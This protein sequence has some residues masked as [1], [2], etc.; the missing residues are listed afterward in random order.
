MRAGVRACVCARVWLGVRLFG[1]LTGEPGPSRGCAD[2]AGCRGQPVLQPRPLNK[3]SPPDLCSPPQAG[4]QPSPRVC[5]GPGTAGGAGA[6]AGRWVGG[7]GVAPSLDWERKIPAGRHLSPATPRTLLASLPHTLFEDFFF[8]LIPKIA[9]PC[10]DPSYSHGEIIF[11]QLLRLNGFF[12]LSRCST[13]PARAR[14]HADTHTHPW[15]PP[16]IPNAN[17]LPFAVVKLSQCYIK[18]G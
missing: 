8:F 18:L 1:E 6:A 7:E 5:A 14:A 4:G 3:P 16:P 12:F 17:P 11:T 15:P 9:F 13:S 2:S 10:R